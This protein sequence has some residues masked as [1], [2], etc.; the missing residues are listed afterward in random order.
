MNSRAAALRNKKIKAARQVVLNGSNEPRVAITSTQAA[1]ES[2]MTWYTDNVRKARFFC[3][4]FQKHITKH[5]QHTHDRRKRTKKLFSIPTKSKEKK[6]STTDTITL[7]TSACQKCA[8]R[9][10]C[11]CIC[12]CTEKK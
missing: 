3:L 2:A 6:L 4:P 9:F 12:S 5:E 10:L 7:L 1:E 11:F 8:R